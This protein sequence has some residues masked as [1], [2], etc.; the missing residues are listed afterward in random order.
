LQA[1]DI[2]T[3]LD[4][5]GLDRVALYSESGGVHS[6]LRFAARYPERVSRFVI[7]GGYVHGRARRHGTPP[8]QDA[9]RLMINEGWKSELEGF[10]AA[11][12]LTYFP[13][14]PLEAVRDAARIMRS[15][16]PPSVEL[17]LRDAIN[18]VDNAGLLQEV[19]CPVLIVHGRNDAVHPLSEARKLAAGLPDARL[20]VL[21]TANHFPIPGHATWTPFLH[22]L[23]AFLDED[24]GA[25]SG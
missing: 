20:H 24:A 10:G 21:D 14:G 13:E 23:T 8:E 4:A 9:L 19:M 18:T 2:R 6:G 7:T 5:A 22:L 25:G 1:E 16:K 17:A 3:V 12:M 15:S 11:F